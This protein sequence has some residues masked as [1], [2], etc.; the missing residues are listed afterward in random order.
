MIVYFQVNAKQ[1][2]YMHTYTAHSNGDYEVT[3]KSRNEKRLNCRETST[4]SGRNSRAHIPSTFSRKR[5][6]R[7]T[8]RMQRIDTPARTPGLSAP[9]RALRY[10]KR[11]VELS[12]TEN[13][14]ATK[15]HSKRKSHHTFH[16]LYHTTSFSHLAIFITLPP[17]IYPISVKTIDT[18][19]WDFTQLLLVSR[20]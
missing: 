19:S 8:I 13:F 6:I 9:S 7:P 12:Q 14:K 17:C 10:V 16:D 15:F 18:H 1:Y 5:W 2:V 4:T 20:K 11:F 3:L